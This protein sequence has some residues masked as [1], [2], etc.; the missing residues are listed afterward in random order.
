MG[1]ILPRLSEKVA[2]NE[3]TL[4]TF[5][6]SDN[7]YTLSAFLEN[8]QGDFPLLTPD[9]IYDY[10]ELLFR[11]EAYLSN[12]HKMYKLTAHVLRRLDENSLSAKIIKTIALIYLVEQFEKLP[13]IHNI[14]VDTFIDTVSDISEINDVLT[15]LIEKDCIVYL[16]RSN[17][18][19]KIKESSG[20]DIPTEINRVIE[21]TST[22][23]KC[24]RDT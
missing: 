4:F 5:L 20:V 13:P 12:I 3:R 21:K 16:K 2:Q 14:L 9:Y 10:F 18:Y 23:N 24:K 8:A 19:L 22:T 6:S 11:K 17:G 1:F 15:D 7:K